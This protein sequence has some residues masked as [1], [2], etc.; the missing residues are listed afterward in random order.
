MV[1]VIFTNAGSQVNSLFIPGTAPC[2]PLW[3]HA[4]AI[5]A[6][7]THERR[8]WPERKHPELLQT[9]D[10]P[11]TGPSYFVMRLACK[12]DDLF[13][14]VLQVRGAVENEYRTEAAPELLETLA[15]IFIPKTLVSCDE[16]E[17]LT[18]LPGEEFLS[19]VDPGTG[20]D[21][22][23]N[24]NGAE[25][26]DSSQQIRCIHDDNTQASLLP[27]AGTKQGNRGTERLHPFLCRPVPERVVT[28]MHLTPH[29]PLNAPHSLCA[30]PLMSQMI[31]ISDWPSQAHKNLAGSTSVL[32]E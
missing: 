13:R 6:G 21:F 7:A 14:N 10:H 8:L 28:P 30:M 17:H 12:R 29:D 27:V 19:E 26:G 23:S 15:A 5:K 1:H 2:K 32:V 22:T 11:V 31:D 18:A 4:T 3:S 16:I 24:A 25:I 20:G 9:N